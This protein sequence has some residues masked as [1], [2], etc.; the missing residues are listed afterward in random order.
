MSGRKTY[1]SIAD[2]PDV[3]PLFPLSGA[4]LLPRGQMPLNIFE[5]RYLD[6]VDDA[7]KTH[8]LIGMI[9]PESEQADETAPPTLS[10]VGCLGRLTQFVD[11]EDG[12]Y[13]IG[14]TGLC[15][16]VLVEEVA[17]RKAYRS[18]RID[19]S[20]FADDFREGLGER[21]VDRE[22]LIRT[23]RAYVKAEDLEINW[24]EVKTAP[25]EALVNALAMMSPFG[26]REK[27][28]LLEAPDL[29]SRAAILVAMTEVDLARRDDGRTAPLQ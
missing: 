26:P 13:L 18:G 19:A 29:Q 4:L 10:R 5:P 12:R 28:A 8:R 9:Q 14:L 7:L 16:F 17:T 11:M 23:L 2:M 20:A 6:M 27:Q 15:R 24:A 21:D 3:V 1:S 25:T 22:D